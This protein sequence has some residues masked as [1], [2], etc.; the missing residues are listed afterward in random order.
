MPFA[1]GSSGTTAPA[2]TV[3]VNVVPAAPVIVTSTG[4]GFEFDTTTAN[5]ACSASS[6]QAGAVWHVVGVSSPNSS[7]ANAVAHELF[8]GSHRPAVADLSAVK[9]ACSVFSTSC[10]LTFAHDEPV[11]A[12]STSSALSRSTAQY[13][14]PV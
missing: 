7:S 10:G 12:P 2:A 6:T 3:V 14:Q 4:R 5:V 13:S 9:H 11:G 8:G 1:C